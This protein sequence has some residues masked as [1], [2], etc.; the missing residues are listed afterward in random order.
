ML[1]QFKRRIGKA[2]CARKAKKFMAN[3]CNCRST[4]PIIKCKSRCTKLKWLSSRSNHSNSIRRSLNT[5]RSRTQESTQASTL[6][7]T[8]WQLRWLMRTLLHLRF[9]FLSYN[10][11]ACRTFLLW[12]FRTQVVK[13]LPSQ[14]WWILQSRQAKRFSQKSSRSRNSRRQIPYGRTNLLASPSRG[15]EKVPVRFWSRRLAT[16][17]RIE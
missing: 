13:N 11:K 4:W 1:I 2:R 3:I 8:S 7:K 9:C 6:K 12:K 15:Q 16:S 14:I 10:S 5:L 17:A